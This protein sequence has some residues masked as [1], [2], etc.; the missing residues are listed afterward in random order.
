MKPWLSLTR[1]YKNRSDHWLIRRTAKG[2]NKA[3]EILVQRYQQGVADLAYRFLADASEA[4]DIA[5]ESFIRLY[6]TAGQYRPER[7]LKVYLFKIAKNLSLDCL[8]KKKPLPLDETEPL[9]SGPSPSDQ[10]MEA[11][12]SKEIFNAVQTLPASQ[13]MALLLQHFEGLSYIETAQIMETTMSA[14]ESLLVRAKKSLH[15]KLKYLV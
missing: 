5:Q 3:F 7:P 12:I 4:E 15:K 9:M 14:V 8:R 10:I 2:D 1:L 6:L 13:R 11:E